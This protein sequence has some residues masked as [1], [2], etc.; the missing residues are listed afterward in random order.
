M[1]LPFS[2]SSR[3]LINRFETAEFS[4]LLASYSIYFLNNLFCRELYY[5]HN[6]NFYPTCV[7]RSVKKNVK[8]IYSLIVSFIIT[9]CVAM[10]FNVKYFFPFPALM[11]Q[12]TIIVITL[13]DCNSVLCPIFFLS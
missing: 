1:F 8:V 7:S 13:A 11:S 6:C 4:D 2:S 10:L 9:G 12:F 5:V 3:P